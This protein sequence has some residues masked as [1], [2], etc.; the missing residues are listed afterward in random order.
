MT[1]E[2]IITICQGVFIVGLLIIGLLAKKYLPSYLQ[3]KGRNL[4]TM[5]DIK[6]ITDKIE[7]VKTQYTKSIEELK[8]DLSIRNE[9]KLRILEKRN[10]TLLKF[11]EDCQELITVK[12]SISPSY[13]IIKQ[14]QTA[15]NNQNNQTST[16]N[17]LIK[18][19]SNFMNYQ[20][21]TGR[22]FLKVISSGTRVFLFYP[23]SN[24]TDEVITSSIKII[25]LIYSFQQIFSEEFT[26]LMNSINEIILSSLTNKS[27]LPINI[28]KINTLIV[29]YSNK[30]QPN[31]TAM[32]KAIGQYG[33]V[34]NNYFN[35][36][37]YK[38]LFNQFSQK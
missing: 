38:Q 37:G 30:I 7:S 23:S 20:L 15:L 31:I 22:L 36:L 8:A 2:I 29:V 10:E 4:A 28:S 34:L 12:F 19:L 3:Q 24:S 18:I 9:Q 27:S 21:S 1:L 14:Y 33:A 32:S 6:E 16:E 13:S 11:F 17:F 25:D 26:N 35:K 5:E